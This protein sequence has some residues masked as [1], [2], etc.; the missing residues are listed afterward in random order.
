METVK[1]LLEYLNYAIDFTGIAIILLG[2]FK[3]FVAFI[4]NEFSRRES[5]LKFWNRI[6]K[7]RCGLATYLLLGLD[8]MIASDIISS[9]INPGLDALIALGGLVLV[10][11][12]IA[13]FLGKELTE[14]HQEGWEQE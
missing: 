2:F 5:D 4:R 7:L 12:V 10:R 6:R 1:Q 8:F 14:L 9:M 11:T 13:F 3:A